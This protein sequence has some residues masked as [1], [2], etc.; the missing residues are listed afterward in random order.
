VAATGAV[1]PGKSVLPPQCGGGDSRFRIPGAC[2]NERSASSCSCSPTRFDYDGLNRVTVEINALDQRK[3][4]AY[5][6]PE[7]SH[8]NR[9]EERDL[10][11][12]LRVEFEYDELNRETLRR[13]HLEG[14]GSAGEVYETI[15]SY[16]DQQHRVSVTDPE[17]NVTE[18]SLD[19]M[20]RVVREVVDPTGLALVTLMSYDG[21]GNVKLVR[22]PRQ[23][24][25]R[26]FR[27]GLG[28]LIERR[29]AATRSTHFEYDGEGLRTAGGD[30]NAGGPGAA[31]PADKEGARSHHRRRANR[32]STSETKPP[33]TSLI[34]LTGMRS[35]TCPAVL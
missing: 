7:G 6:D 27:D 15:T 30:Q 9:S 23:F 16:D 22:N 34:T 14:S 3:E 24:E 17:Q 20:D 33:W 26:S 31:P 28:R 35:S 11:R 12:G 25:T 8:V 4:T 2:P 19:G 5:D 32:P 29:D 18:R 1:G 21:L 13:V 10:T